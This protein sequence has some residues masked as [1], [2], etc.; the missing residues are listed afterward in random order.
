MGQRF[1]HTVVHR[2]VIEFVL[3]IIRKK[4]LQTLA[5]DGLIDRLPAERALNQNRRAVSHI[6][7]NH[8]VGQLRTPDVAQRRVHRVH[9]IEPRINQ[10]P[11]EIEDH[12]LNRVRVKGAA[13]PNHAHSG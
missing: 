3:P 13:G 5:H 6:A 2:G 11:I 10:R 7:G 9:Q 8:I 4:K 1:M 12:Q